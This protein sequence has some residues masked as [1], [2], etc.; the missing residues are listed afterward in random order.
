LQL[1]PE[2][3]INT[4]IDPPEF[5]NLYNSFRTKPIFLFGV[6][7][8]INRVAI[9]ETA[10][11]TVDNINTNERNYSPAVGF[12]AG[13]S[14]D[15]PMR[16]NF[17]LN[18]ELYYR[19][20]QYTYQSLLLDFADLTMI[21]SQTWISLPVIAKYQFEGKKTQ[22]FV[23]LGG[24]IDFLLDDIA[25]AT[26]QD[27]VDELTQRE[28]KDASISL[29]GQRNQLNFGAVITAGARFKDLIGKGFLTLEARYYHGL[30]NL[31]NK[32]AR[33]AEDD[34]NKRLIHDYGFIASDMN[35]HTFT[36]SLGYMLPKYNPKILPNKGKKK[37]KRTQ[38]PDQKTKKEKK[39][40]K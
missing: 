2:Y 32:D 4:A 40:A 8:G 20:K 39:K 28:I 6:K 24:T 33:Y 22:P 36:L 1:N 11:Y 15:I 14:F 23:G 17:L 18:P 31:T 35:L 21:Q 5:I 12:Q 19:S 38:L 13:I 25:D 27:F 30:S 9:N 10:Y 7:A 26:R 16:G 29:L 37:A 34:I 3:E